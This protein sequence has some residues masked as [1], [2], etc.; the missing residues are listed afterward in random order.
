MKARATL[1][2]AD[3]IVL[4]GGQVRRNVIETAGTKLLADPLTNVHAE[5]A[6][7]FDVSKDAHRVDPH[8]LS[9]HIRDQQ[10]VGLWGRQVSAP[11]IFRGCRKDIR[12]LVKLSG[13]GQRES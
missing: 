7:S 11:E 5:L 13:A 6:R 12:T 8:A 9:L 1:E 3:M 2:Q 10:V 4:V